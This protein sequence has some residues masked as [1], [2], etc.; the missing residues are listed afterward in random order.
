M[1]VAIFGGRGQLGLR[2]GA[3]LQNLGEIHSLAHNEADITDE[4]ITHDAIADLRPDLI[5]NAA[6]YTNVDGAETERELAHAVNARGVA[7]LSKAAA[8]MEAGLL[9]FSTDYV[10]DGKSRRPYEEMDE[11]GP[12]NEYGR[13]KLL[14]ERAALE[15]NAPAIVV[16][17]GWLYSSEPGNFLTKIVD[18]LI[19]DGEARVVDDQFGAPTSADSVA[20]AV[21][22]MLGGGG[23]LIRLFAAKSGVYHF[24]ADGDASW[25]DFA[26]GIAETGS[27]LGLLPEGATVRRQ[28][29][30]DLDLAAERPE[31]SKLNT[32]KWMAEF[33]QRPV[34]WRDEL[35][36]VLGKMRR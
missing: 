31:Y 15:G 35:S 9:H 1:R 17:L 36:R 33:G 12:V 5:V 14:G 6:A 4:T 30:S 25:Y 22:Q 32:V 24:A 34:H 11:T 27:A 2:L 10:F 21:A 20:N 16:R 29:T 3:A 7:N 26:A 18:R 28:S 23:P 13:S 19:A 8:K